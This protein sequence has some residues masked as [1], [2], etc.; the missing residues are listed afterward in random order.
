MENNQIT[1]PMAEA[2]RYVANAEEVIKRAKYDPE[3][4]AT[5]TANT[6][7]RPAT[8]SGKAV[9]SPLMQCFTCDNQNA[10]LSSSHC[11]FVNNANCKCFA[12]IKII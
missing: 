10:Y 2:R 8:T 12:R 6:S 1:D 4:K 5:P 3:L 9:S 7:R 11:L